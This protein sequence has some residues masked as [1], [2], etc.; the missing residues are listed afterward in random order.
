MV[1]PAASRISSTVTPARPAR[2][3]I[4]TFIHSSAGKLGDVK[5]LDIL[6]PEARAF[7][8]MNRGADNP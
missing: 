2:Q 6:L 7:Y 1:D 4:P 8:V 5:E 3:L